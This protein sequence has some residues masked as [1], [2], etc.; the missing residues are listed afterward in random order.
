[1]K[2]LS[3][4]G[5]ILAIPFFLWLSLYFYEIENKTYTEYAL[6]IFV[7]S[8]FIL[9]ALFTFMYFRNRGL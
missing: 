9:D 5:D 2:D 6:M 7:I 3:H 4:I 8:G 1:M